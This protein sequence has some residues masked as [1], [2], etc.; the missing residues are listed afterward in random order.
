[1]SKDVTRLYRQFV[2]SHYKLALEPNA[3]KM[4]F[5]GRVEISGQ[6]VGRPTKRLT[7]HQK[8]LKIIA[9]SVEAHSKGS[10]SQIPIDRINSHNRFDEVRLH[11]PQTLYPGSYTII[12]EFSGHISRLMNG[13]YPCF[14]EQNGQPQKL[15]ATQFESHHARE[16]FPCIDEPE[17]KA[18]FDLSL[19]APSGQTVI[20]NTPIEKQTKSGA[21]T[22]TQFATTPKMSVYLLA[23]V[24]GDMAF[25]EAKTKTG[26]LV[27]AYATPDNIQLVDFALDI[28]VKCLDFYNHYFGLDY[29][30]EKCDLIALPDFANGAM[31]NWGCITFREQC[32]LV[33]PSNSSLGTKQYVAM[34][35]AHELAH[36]WFGNL[37][38]MRWWT[39]LW[40]NEG[41]AS[42]IEYLAVDNIFPDWNMWTQFITDEQ[43]SA[44]RLDALAS[45]HP[46]EVPVHHPDEIRTI[47]DTISY[48]KG[49]SLIHMLQQYIGADD[50]RAGLQHYLK[51]H[52]YG[53]TDTSDL[54]AS[55]QEVSGKPVSKFMHA[56]T[57]QPGFPVVQ[58]DLSGR[59]LSLQQTRFYADP[60]Q[61]ALAKPSLWPIAC[62]SNPPGA[63]ELLSTKTSMTEL[64]ESLS[65]IKLNQNQSGFYRLIYDQNQMSLLAQQVTAGKLEPLDRLGLL[66]DA[67]EAAKAGYSSSTAALR[68]LDSYSQEDNNAVWDVIAGGL[69][70]IRVVMDD[71]PLREAMQPYVQQLV[72]IQL[73]R[74][75]WKDKAQ[76]SHFDSLLRPT[77]IGLAAASEDAAVVKE[78][79]SRFKLMTKPEDLPADLRSVIYNT[80]ARH[81]NQ[82]TFDKLLNLHNNSISSEERTT[83][84]SALTG[85]KQPEII[86]QALSLIK[87]DS[88]RLQDAAYWVAYSFMNRH[89]KHATWQ[90]LQ[91]NWEWL[92]KNLGSDLSFARF[93]LYA[94]RSFSDAAFLKQYKTFFEPR[95][96]PAIE[97]AYRQGLETLSWQIAWKKRDLDNIRHEFVD[98][99]IGPK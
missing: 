47:F 44:L 50:F 85:L 45:T 16:V 78:C 32:M 72:Q 14:F 77:I 84:A 79:L 69:G 97:R 19:T 62:N 98:R 83:L 18:T 40:L 36:Q 28:A 5:A 91:T 8:G 17:A 1:M 80:A 70:N 11:S 57:S 27:R 48:N 55:L 30:L 12:I 3:D 7:L 89:S 6:K 64:S 21:L 63:P 39:D 33:D 88:I 67:F 71:Q 9:V 59:K 66:S 94:A 24:I 60:S 25:K 41:F 49:A 75:G 15:L 93:P 95:V 46:V 87:T 10:S 61:A 38:T 35:V 37:V 13:L 26:V 54:W 56:W 74:L 58:S 52:Q 42:W 20:S 99:I 29:P 81:G 76:E 31:E 65:S 51:K 82:S 86:D 22:T 4:I 96:N 68:L 2:P 34:V 92:E 43:Q 23:F 53:N 90:W 73:K